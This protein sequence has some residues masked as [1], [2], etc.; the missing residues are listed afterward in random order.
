M[1]SYFQLSRD[2]WC[3]EAAQQAQGFKPI[4]NLSCRRHVIKEVHSA[5]AAKLLMWKCS[6]QMEVVENF[7]YLHS[8]I[9]ECMYIAAFSIHSLI[10]SSSSVQWHS[11]FQLTW[12]WVRSLT[13]ILLASPIE[14]KG[15]FT[16]KDK[17]PKSATNKTWDRQNNTQY[18]NTHD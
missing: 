13:F 10:C 17:R 7:F 6:T 15:S 4:I 8:S 3:R 11:Q 2:S 12:V 18:K 1:L 9:D 14:I 5:L 16:R